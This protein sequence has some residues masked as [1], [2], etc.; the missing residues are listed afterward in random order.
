MN[1]S[2]KIWKSW[3][4]KKMIKNKRWLKMKEKWKKLLQNGKKLIKNEKN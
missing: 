2:K 1:K 3:R 4:I